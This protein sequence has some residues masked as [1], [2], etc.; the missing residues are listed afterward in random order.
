MS[1]LKL[2][3]PVELTVFCPDDAPLLRVF[4]GDD[5]AD[6]VPDE[7]PVI[8]Q[9][10]STIRVP[11]HRPEGSAPRT[12]GNVVYVPVVGSIRQASIHAPETSQVAPRLRLFVSDN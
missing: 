5:D 4:R 2:F 9:L 6:A 3:A 10:P 11:Q 1:C 12:G 7:E 8:L